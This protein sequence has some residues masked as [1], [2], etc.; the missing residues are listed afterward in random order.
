LR[1]WISSGRGALDEADRAA[2]DGDGAG[3]SAA[4]NKLDQALNRNSRKVKDEFGF[5]ACG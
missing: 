3:V 4:T 5:S 1:Q 2:A